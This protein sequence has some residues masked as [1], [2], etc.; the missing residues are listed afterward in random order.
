M[1]ADKTDCKGLSQ[2]HKF[3]FS[4]LIAN[5]QTMMQWANRGRTGNITVGS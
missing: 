1:F 3:H 5:V 4:W 2:R